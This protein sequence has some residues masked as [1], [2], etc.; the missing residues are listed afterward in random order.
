MYLL[1]FGSF[2]TQG[3]VILDTGETVFWKWFGKELIVMDTIGNCQANRTG[4]PQDCSMKQASKMLY[5]IS[6][7]KK[8]SK[9][10]K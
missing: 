7:I 6:L 4:E 3:Y 5:Q 10:M 9:V 1:I 8:T 2:A